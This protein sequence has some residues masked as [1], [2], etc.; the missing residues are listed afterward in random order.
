MSNY[1]EIDLKQVKTYS[2]SNRKS[3]VNISDFAKV[4]KKGSSFLQF[5]QYLPQ[6]LIG[7]ELQELVEAIVRAFR[8]EK[9]VIIMMGAHVIKCGLSPLIISLMEKNIVKCIALNG[10][11]VIHDVETAYWGTTSEDVAHALN[12]GSFGMVKETPE[13]INTALAYGKE[14]SLGFGEAVGKRICEDISSNKELSIVAKGFEFKIPVTVHVALGTDIVHQHNSSDGATIGELSYRDFKIFCN[15]VAKLGDGGVLLNF[16]SAVVLPEVFLKALTVARNL[17][18]NVHN[19]ITAN[20]DMLSHYRPMVNVVQRP[21][22]T[23]GRGFHFIGHHEIMI[24]L[25]IAAITEV[26]ESNC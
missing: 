1:K 14:K 23:G 21:N 22:L 25:L 10:A 24:P 9:P 2:I 17:D 16:G 6:I 15:Q 19:F 7:K 5:W 18:Y 3:K 8:N 11:G 4:H 13:I 20:F 12:D 26:I